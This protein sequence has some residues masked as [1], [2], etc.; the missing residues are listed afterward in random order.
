MGSLAQTFGRA[1]VNPGEALDA[2]RDANT[3]IFTS[4][5]PPNKFMHDCGYERL[6]Q[7]VAAGELVVDDRLMG[8]LGELNSGNLKKAA[9]LLA[10]HEQ[11]DVV[12]P[13]YERHEDTFDDMATAESL[14]PRDQ[15]SIPISY[16]CTRDNLVT[17]GDL[18]IQ[19][20]EDRVKYYGKL[21]DRMKEIEGLP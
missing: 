4:V 19:N 21:M 3:T 6:K 11:V 8:A 12:Q 13:V 5:Y 18:A 14:L 17:L 9:D 20:A 7:C 15:T 1:V 2:L 10:E 16:E